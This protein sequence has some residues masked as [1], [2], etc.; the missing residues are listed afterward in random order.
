[1]KFTIKNITVAVAAAFSLWI[2]SVQSGFGA[3]TNVFVGFNG[4]LRFSPTNVTI[5]VNDSVIWTWQGSDHSTTSGTNG[6]PG[7]DNGV[8]AGSWDSGINNL[9][10]SFTNTFT[11]TGIYSYYCTVH[12]SV[13]MTGQVFVASSSLPPTL[14]I[15]QPLNGAVF[16]TPANVAIQVVVTNGNGTV[17][18]V[19]FLEGTTVLANETAAPFSTT[20]N[21]LATGNYTLTAIALDNN[22]LSATNTVS[23]SVV[24]P[25]TV[26]LTNVFELSGGT[27]FQFSYFA[28]PGLDYVVLRSADLFT[29]VPLATNMAESNPVVFTDLTA[30]N[31]LNF[32][33]VGLLPNP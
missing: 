13:G 30:T 11:S 8:P 6:T 26:A 9:P 2:T 21:D 29:W 20:A 25:T 12:H 7:D 32:Y 33:R 24:T 28:N 17:T 10:H 3:T 15:T 18:N 4:A 19:Q 1:M 16:A 14:A 5:S 22:D 31:N 27:N 23:I